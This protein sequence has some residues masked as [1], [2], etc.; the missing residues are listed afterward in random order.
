MALSDSFENGGYNFLRGVNSDKKVGHFDSRSV[1]SN[2][3]DIKKVL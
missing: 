2:P 1:P 3:N